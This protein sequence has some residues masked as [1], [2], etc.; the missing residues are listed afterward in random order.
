MNRRVGFIGLGDQGGPMA[1]AL[2]ERHDLY[3]WARRDAAYADTGDVAFQR[4]ES[5]ERL[6][7]R[8]DFLCLCLPGD[9]ELEDILFARGA[10]AA[11]PTGGV[12]INHATGDPDAAIRTSD[13]LSRIGVGFLDAPVSGGRPGALERNLTCLSAAISKCWRTAGP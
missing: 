11:L 12:V 4:A 9:A 1:A 6:A 7:R 3:V 2:A 5:P 10:A 8:V 13:A